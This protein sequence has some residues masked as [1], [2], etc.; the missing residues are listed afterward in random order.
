MPQKNVG[1]F[2]FSNAK[3]ALLQQTVAPFE[4]FTASYLFFFRF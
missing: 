4:K 3:M 1:E 2:S